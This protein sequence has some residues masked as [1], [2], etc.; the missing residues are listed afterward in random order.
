MEKK[1]LVALLALVM[2]IIPFTALTAFAAETTYTITVDGAITHG[3]VT[4]NAASASTGTTVT[5]TVTPDD[6]YSLASNTLKVSDGTNEIEITPGANDTYT[7][8]MPAANVT[9]SARFGI[10]N[11]EVYYA[12]DKEN[13]VT[14]I[15]GNGT[16]SA[17]SWQNI[18]MSKVV[19]EE[20]ITAI[21]ANAFRG[22]VS[23]ES[24]TIPASVESIGNNAFQGGA[25]LS[26]IIYLGTS[27]PSVHATAFK[28]CDGVSSVSVPAD[29]TGSTFAGIPVVKSSASTPTYAASLTT[30]DATPVVT[31]YLTLDDA[32]TAAQSADGSTITLLDDCMP[33]KLDW[34]QIN[35]G[36]FTI[37]LNGKNIGSYNISTLIVNGA[38]ITLEDNVGTGTIE[39]KVDLWDGHLTIKGGNYEKD[40]RLLDGEL[41][42]EGGNFSS[43]TMLDS[44]LTLSGGTIDLLQIKDDK[45]TMAD[46][47]LSGHHYYDANG[48]IVDISDL[49][50]TL[51]GYDLANVTVKKGADLSSDAVIT[52]KSAT[53]NG[54]EQKP[55]VTVTVGGVELT[56]GVDFAVN[57]PDGYDFTNAG[58]SQI[59]IEGVG[60]YTGE[61]QAT[62]IIGKATLT[63]SY[64]NLINLTPT[65][66]YQTVQEVR[67][68][69]HP[70][71]LDLQHVTI[72]Y[73]RS[74]TPLESAP[75][76]AGAYNVL[77][78]VEGSPNYNNVTLYYDMVIAPIQ[79]VAGQIIVGGVN[80]E[81]IYNGSRHEPTVYIDL[82]IPAPTDYFGCTVA[83]ENNIN[84]GTA[85]VVVSGNYAGTATFEI[86]KA[87][88]KVDLG[89]PL[90]KVMAG[91]V[92]NL[93]PTTTA[94]DKL[95][96]TITLTVLDGDGYSVNGNQIT[97]DEG[98]VVGSSI[99]VRVQHPETTNYNATICEV[100]L[101]VGIPT[102]DTS[103]IEADIAALKADVA[104]LN[105][106]IKFKADADEIA[107]KLSEIT[108][109]IQTLEQNGAT[110]AELEQ[111]KTDLTSAY[112]KAIEDA[113]AELKELVDSNS[114]TA[115]ELKQALA[116]INLVLGA[117]DTTYVTHDELADELA[118]ALV[119]VN[120]AVNK[121]N[122][123]IIPK[124]QND[125]TQNA[126]DIADLDNTIGN[127]TATVDHMKT[128]LSGLSLTDDRL[129]GL[130]STLDISL[131][132]LS[133]S[134]DT[135]AGR[136]DMA[137]KE[138]DVLRSELAVKYAELQALINTN[139]SNLD[140][141]ND[142]LKDIKDILAL[143][144]RRNS[145][146]LWEP[147]YCQHCGNNMLSCAEAES[148]QTTTW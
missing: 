11:G 50:P 104:E 52:V 63:E 138:I 56:Q 69:T 145:N 47:L 71:S 83:Y 92:M 146:T 27:E 26:D 137:E 106:L 124:I 21:N 73:M 94:L 12:N 119:A 48:S 114:A 96:E 28:G 81:F 116:E 127:L 147:H 49:P 143:G 13:G 120:A 67:I 17:G 102:I 84:A 42:V 2:V 98:V 59:S 144:N 19:I 133:D 109:K 87:T 39:H 130:I 34:F 23:I 33:T 75:I 82:N 61:A 15:F 131:S 88:P 45:S 79:L 43:I 29:Y 25:S 70:A 125:V 112:T 108:N 140:A 110:D 129:E 18:I 58:T 99:T 126:G 20:G 8:T 3:T 111:A 74:G 113:I 37:D 7:F 4:S 139:S 55:I 53:Y 68:G 60:N 24:I 72:V 30:A 142:T 93:N 46:I 22:L 10:P 86:Q 118:E 40:V 66:A 136:V 1:I 100:T 78:I 76:N 77:L 16:I 35:S 103:E 121:L 62:Y 115:G 57:Y 148:T 31:Y 107:K 135:L 5:L 90:D 51:H 36:T 117:L 6:G 122:D 97:I 123:E 132:T 85:T 89:A 95:V 54:T 44:A 128:I 9:V 80:E 32:I 105:E 65:Y 64:I 38:E 141:I 101:E 91:Y 134:L 14:T 41:V